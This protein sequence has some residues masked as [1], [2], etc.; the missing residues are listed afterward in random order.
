[1]TW[2]VLEWN[3]AAIGNAL[4]GAGLGTLL[5][6]WL[7]DLWQA[8]RRAGYLAMRL[9]RQLEAYA[10]ECAR[11]VESNQNAQHRP[12]EQFPDWNISLPKLAALP[13]D[14]E[15]WRSLNP[16]TADRVLGLENHIEESRAHISSVVEFSEAELEFQVTEQASLRGIEAW[17]A[18][19]ELRRKYR[20]GPA[21]P[22][23]D[24]AQ[25]LR[26]AL[27]SARHMKE[28]AAEENR[29]AWSRINT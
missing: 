12:D 19:A 2:N 8:R 26:A 27:T 1:M 10:A 22:A 20:L 18:A 25:S 23:W 17:D 13:D 21:K 15:G 9:A 7:K 4:V 14:P 11:L 16:R 28:Q 24:Y 29:R 6:S 3:W 5:A